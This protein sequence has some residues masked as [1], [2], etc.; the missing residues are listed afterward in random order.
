MNKAAV[1]MLNISSCECLRG[2]SAIRDLV[3]VNLSDL[4]GACSQTNIS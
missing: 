1:K 4:L 2:I 3:H